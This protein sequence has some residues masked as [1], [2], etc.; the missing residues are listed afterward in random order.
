MRKEVP[1]LNANLTKDQFLDLIVESFQS[2]VFATVDSHGDPVSNVADIEL[3]DGGKLIFATTYEK[4]FYQRLKNHPVV[5]ITA[6]KGDETMNSVGLTLNGKVEEVDR[7]YL[8]QIFAARPEMNRI[9]GENHSE[10]REILRPF[11]ITPTDGSVYDLRQ[12]PIFQK[13]FEF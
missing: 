2:V 7:K 12:S 10:R 9:S 3:K 6:L 8:D 11:A 13:H 5:S 4:P 1:E